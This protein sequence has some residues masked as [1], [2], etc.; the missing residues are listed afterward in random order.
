[1]AQGPLTA[2]VAQNPAGNFAPLRVGSNGELLIGNQQQG[3]TAWFVDA[4]TG[5]NSNSGLS[6]ADALP[7]ITAALTAASAG[8]TVFIATGGYAE[9]IT[10]TKDYITII[11]AAPSGYGRPDW[12]PATGSALVVQAQGF[13]AQNIR[14][15]TDADADVVVQHGNGFAYQGCVF[16]GDAQGATHGLLRL[17][18]AVDDSFSASEGL[19]AGNLFRG[20]ASGIGIALQYAL[21][22]A[23]GEGTSD[24]TIRGNRFVGNGVDLKSLTNTNGGGAGIFLRYLIDSNFF[25]TVGASFVYA[26]MD[27]GAAGDLAANSALVCGNFFADEA[28]IASQFAI[29]GQP[30]V[31]FTGNYDATGIIDGHTF[32]S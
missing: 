12:V 23:G 32:N 30:N 4:A 1:M 26:D 24:N 17:V 20:A 11:G 25:M 16:D 10:L 27:Q 15:S 31:I 8:D 14:F 2:L 22:A 29:G 9:N 5:S 28:L 6:W 3:G 21:A 7:T 19:I 13:V 18:G